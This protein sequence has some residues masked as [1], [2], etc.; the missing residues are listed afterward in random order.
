MWEVLP[1]ATEDT[2]CSI[3]R[4]DHVLP[5]GLHDGSFDL[6]RWALSEDAMLF[7]DAWFQWFL[8]GEPTPEPEGDLD[9]LRALLLDEL[10]Q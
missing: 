2:P 1:F 5:L 10:E 6:S 8:S 7:V 9:M 3:L 4:I